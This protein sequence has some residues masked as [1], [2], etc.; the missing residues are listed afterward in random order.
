MAKI[1]PLADI[2]A[3]YASITKINANMAKIEAAIENTVSRDGSAP[4]SMLADLDM[5]DKQLI[6][7]GAPMLDHH[8]ATK[9]YVDGL[10]AGDDVFVLSTVNLGTGWENVLVKPRT[11]IGPVSATSYGFLA[12]NSTASAT[13]NTTAL[14]AA[15]NTNYWVI[16][17]PGTGYINKITHTQTNRLTGVG[18]SILKRGN[19]LN[20]YV[21]YST[22]KNDMI[23][24]NF[25]LDMNPANNTGSGSHTGIRME[26]GP[27]RWR[28]ENIKV[29]GGQGLFSGSPVGSGFS[30]TGG[31]ANGVFINCTFESCYDGYVLSGHT[32]ARDYRSRF[33]GCLRNGG[34][35]A[36]SSHRFESFGVYAVGNSTTYGGAGFQ[37]NTSN[38]CKTYGGYFASNTLG[39]GLQ[40]NT[41]N[42]CETHGGLFESNGISGLDFFASTFGRVYGGYALSNAIRGIEI[43]STSDSCV[44]FG[45]QGAS[46]TDVDISIFRS[47]NVTLFNSK[48]NVRIWDAAVIATATVSAGGSGYTVGDVLTV[49]GG[50]KATAATFTVATLGG[51]GAVA[52]VTVS[53]A[54]NYWTFPTEPASVTGGTGTGA[55]FTFTVTGENSNTSA[56]THIIGGHLNDTILVVSG[57]TS[58]VRLSHVRATTITDTGS[59]IISADG[60]TNYVVPKIAL[61]LQNSWVAYDSTWQEPVYW[62]TSDRIVTVRG[63]I[64]DGT[65]TAATV[66]GNLPA[67]YRP[68]KVEGPFL[69]FGSAGTGSVYVSTNGDIVIQ[70]PLSAPRSH[71][72]ISFTV[73]A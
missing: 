72:D 7:L 6:N 40:H 16:L 38:D 33:T 70:S 24:E 54:G 34:L 58:N 21:L 10:L 73:S 53:N 15:L 30:S 8:A 23:Y 29:T 2:G 67:G 42:R 4:N 44:V 31:G 41:A 32:D 52:T 69:C 26:G 3:N 50:T 61:T 46:N 13:S 68:S 48:G 63:T 12:N 59:H 37:I 36:S 39:H 14:Q 19:S 62:K 57:A 18:T 35:V 45:F 56:N 20:D 65:T 11:D 49:S 5:N 43:D 71:L 9:E 55:T 47:A 25:T 51:G 28:L 64:K 17:P 27:N 1:E 66:I 60:C 22:G